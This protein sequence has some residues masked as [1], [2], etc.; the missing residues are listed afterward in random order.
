MGIVLVCHQYASVLFDPS[1]IFFYVFAFFASSFDMMCESLIMHIH[2]STPIC[3]I[4]V[5]DQV[6]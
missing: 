6:Y 5:V 3:D 4:L 2:I 1:S